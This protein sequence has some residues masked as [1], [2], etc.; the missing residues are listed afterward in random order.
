MKITKIEIFQ[1]QLLPEPPIVVSPL[2]VVHIT[3]CEPFNVFIE[4]IPF[5]VNF[6]LLNYKNVSTNYGSRWS[7]KDFIALNSDQ[8]STFISWPAA[9]YDMLDDQFPPFTA[10]DLLSVLSWL[11]I[12]DKTNSKQLFLYQDS[13]QFTP[14]LSGTYSISVSA[15]TIEKEFVIFNKIPKLT[16]VPLSDIVITS[17]EGK[18]SGKFCE[19]GLYQIGYEVYNQ[20]GK[21]TYCLSLSA[22]NPP[23]PSPSPTPTVTPTVAVT[24]TLTITPTPTVT[25]TVT[26][27]PTITKTPYATPD[28]TVTPTPTYTPTIT[29]TITLTP[30]ITPQPTTWVMPEVSPR[31]EP[32]PTHCPHPTQTPYPTPT[33]SKKC[34]CKTRPCQH[35]C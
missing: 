14:M 18:F 4:T 27:T 21:N 8:S 19:E 17:G 5:P 2:N 10:N 35:T 30:T 12:H 25:P 13:I 1:D 7:T 9:P 29:P 24:P 32:P 3:T 28:S 33:P 20:F 31:C 6:N 26:V 34:S 15:L 22:S 23:P 11:I 16:A